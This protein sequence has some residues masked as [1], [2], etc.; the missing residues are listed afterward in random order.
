MCKA[1]ARSCVHV[2]SYVCVYVCVCVCVCVCLCVCVCVRARACMCVCTRVCGYVCVYARARTSVCVCV[3]VCVFALFFV[4]GVVS[5]TPS[6][7][8]PAAVQA[9]K[10]SLKSSPPH[11]LS[12][13]REGRAPL[14]LCQVFDAVVVSQADRVIL[15]LTSL[16]LWIHR[17]RTSLRSKSI[18]LDYGVESDVPF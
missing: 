13:G 16:K 10:E 12:S 8:A 5:F 1:D 14:D 15:L 17:R 2:R 7:C 3:C 9:V 18:V 4:M 6:Q 11:L